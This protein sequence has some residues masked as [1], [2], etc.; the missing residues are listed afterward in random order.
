MEDIKSILDAI[1]NGIN[2]LTGEIFD[3]SILSEDPRI[4]REIVK[5]ALSTQND[6]SY[7]KKDSV[8]ALHRDSK[9]IF[10]AL[11]AWRLEM[12]SMLQLPAYYIFSNKQ[13][14]AI[15]E[16]D[17]IEKADLLLIKGIQTN[18]YEAY[19]DEVYEVLRPFITED[20][21]LNLEKALSNSS[22]IISKNISEEK[23][24]KECEEKDEEA[25]GPVEV[26]LDSVDLDPA[27]E[28]STI[29]ETPVLTCKKCMLYRNESCFGQSQICDDFRNSVDIS[30]EER[31]NWPTG[32]QGPYGTL[33]R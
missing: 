4:A 31:K 32:M 19:G 5:L 30:E 18:K 27:C 11:S 9:A 17:V 26:S 8:N 6:I 3:V 7:T 13:L 22:N 20:D 15:A 14:W 29:K 10:E 23:T 21:E 1:R 25:Q 28:D 2:P 24:I 12:A 33:H 16:G